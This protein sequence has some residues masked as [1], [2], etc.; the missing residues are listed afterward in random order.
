M[1]FNQ[2]RWWDRNNI[3]F[4]NFTRWERYLSEAR[5]VAGNKPILLWQVPVGNQYFRTVD[6]SD[7]HY[8]DNRGEYFFGHIPELVQVGIIGI[9]FGAGSADNTTNNDSGDGVT[10][11][12][13]MC[14]TDGISSGQIC[15]DHES[16]VPDDDGG[17]IRFSAGAYYQRPLVLTDTP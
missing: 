11:P 2:S 8:Q 16:T 5:G 6:N 9:M 13:P 7:H 3:S 1:K 15:N 14:T 12:P 17:F 10:N 4:P